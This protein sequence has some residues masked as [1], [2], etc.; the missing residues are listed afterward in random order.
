M[1]AGGSCRTSLARPRFR[2]TESDATGRQTLHH[3]GTLIQTDAKLNLGASGGPL[4]NLKGEM[5]GLCV[6][7]AA[8]A[9]YETSAGY[10]IPVDATFRRVLEPL[11]EGR[12]VEYGFLGVQPANLQAEE[13]LAGLRGVRVERV[14]PGTPAA[15]CGLKPDDV[16]TA[17]GDA[18]IH[19]ADELILE[20]GRLPVEAVARLASFA[21]AGGGRSTRR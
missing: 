15:R 13:V 8:V 1:P 3:F 18:P 6:A 19:D 20:V 2:P 10:A 17:V 7:L 11:K 5:I 12:E 21:T 9:G 16:I 4:L 14:V